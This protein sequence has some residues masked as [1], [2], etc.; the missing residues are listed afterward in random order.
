M[1]NQRFK[2]MALSA[3]F[4]SALLAAGAQAASV[5]D[6]M[7][8]GT[9]KT[10]AAK[11][12]QAKIDKVADQ[13]FD[14]LQDFKA[15]NK[16]I[17]GLRVYNAQLENQIAGQK[18]IMADLAESIENASLMERQITPLTI[19]M[20][21]SLDQFVSLDMPFLQ[22]ER[23]ERVAKLR[24][25]IERSDLSSAEKF[26][27]VLEAYDIESEYAQKIET[28]TGKID[29]N[30]QGREVNILRVGRIALM[31]QTPDQTVTGAWD[32]RSGSW[33]ELGSGYRSA[34]AQGIKVAKK[35]ASIEILKLPILSPEAAQ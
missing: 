6:V 4:S 33:V 18:E 15:V 9:K 7:K 2:V 29:I 20:I 5:D 30:G 16:Q 32:K 34:V 27:Q 19:E 10:A 24:E 21:N 31:Y 8:A 12:A 14:L 17:E 25:S 35:Q 11:S 13:T 23:Q 26:R 28:Y 22:Q 3:I 1:K